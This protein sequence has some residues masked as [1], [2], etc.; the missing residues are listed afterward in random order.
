MV[1]NGRHCT[2]LAVRGINKGQT[3]AIQQS[4]MAGSYQRTSD[5]ER[6]TKYDKVGVS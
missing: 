3:K 1:P 6:T 5:A 4:D 2:P